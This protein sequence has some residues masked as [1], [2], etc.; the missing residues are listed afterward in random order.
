MRQVMTGANCDNSPFNCI[1][2]LDLHG[3][4]IPWYI[5]IYLQWSRQDFDRQFTI[6]VNLQRKVQALEKQVSG[7]AIVFTDLVIFVL[8]FFPTFLPISSHIFSCFRAWLCWPPRGSGS[9]S[10][11]LTTICDISVPLLIRYNCTTHDLWK[12][13]TYFSAVRSGYVETVEAHEPERSHDSCAT[14]MQMMRFDRHFGIISKFHFC[15]SCP[16]LIS[17]PRC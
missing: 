9:R 17:A 2:L 11:I 7:L 13:K 6:M 12:N 8:P 15:D 1:R 16:H 14:T 4:Y 10:H 5:H 3:S